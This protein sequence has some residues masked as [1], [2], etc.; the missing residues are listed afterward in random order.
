MAT[1]SNYTYDALLQTVADIQPKG[2]RPVAIT[3]RPEALAQLRKEN[4]NATGSDIFSKF[5]G[6]PIYY[7]TGQVEFARV[8][9]DDAALCEYLETN[10]KT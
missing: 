7:K 6:I 10:L 9:Y 8:G 2:P 4:L 1:D 5:A 3:V